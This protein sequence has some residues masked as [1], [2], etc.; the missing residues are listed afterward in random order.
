MKIAYTFICCLI[1]ILGFGQTY[2][3]L[4]DYRNQQKKAFLK[5]DFGPLRKE[6]IQYLDYYP[7]NTK[8]VV[9]AQL[10]LL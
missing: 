3:T 4:A 8:Y 9:V 5:D 6:N 1:P 2:N 10:E 7:A